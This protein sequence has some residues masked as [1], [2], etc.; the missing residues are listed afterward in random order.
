MATTRSLV[1]VLHEAPET[2]FY[3]A[4]AEI[5]ELDF[6]R[7]APRAIRVVEEVFA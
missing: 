6:L 5:A 7:S 3:A 2:A 1:M 4:L